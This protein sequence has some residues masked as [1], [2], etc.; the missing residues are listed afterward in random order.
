MRLPSLD[1]RHLLQFRYVH[2][3]LTYT[4]WSPGLQLRFFPGTS[5]SSTSTTRWPTRSARP[6]GCSSRCSRPTRPTR[7]SQADQGRRAPVRRP[8]ARHDPA[9]APHVRHAVRSRGPLRAGDVA[10]QRDGR[11]RPR[12][13]ADPALQDPASSGRARASWRI[14]C[15]ARPIGCTRRSTRSPHKT[16][17]HP[18]A[19]EINRLENEADRVYQEA[20]RTLFDPE[21]DPIIDHQMEGIVRRAGADHGRV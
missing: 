11:D 2:F 18:H 9:A 12:R 4:R 1:Y 3:W 13:G 16:P 21:T 17:V 10:R 14:P 6:R 19:V 20:V 8:D 15:P 7:Q 5:S